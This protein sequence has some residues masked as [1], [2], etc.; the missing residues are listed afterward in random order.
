MSDSQPPQESP[1]DERYSRLIAYAT[2]NCR[3]C[4]Q[5]GP[6]AALF[7]MLPDT[8][9]VGYGYEPAS[10][11]ILGAWDTPALFKIL[12]LQEHIEMRT[13]MGR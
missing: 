7:D 10:P 8:R 5:P 4:P 9:M 12:R 11:L 6:W 3:I 13:S 1:V 2:A